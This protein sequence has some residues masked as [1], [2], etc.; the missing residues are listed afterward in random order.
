MEPARLVDL[1]GD[2]RS[3]AALE[4]RDHLPRAVTSSTR[5]TSASSSASCCSARR[6]PIRSISGGGRCP[7]G[8]RSRS[9]IIVVGGLAIL[10]RLRLLEIAVFFWVAFAAGIAVLAASGHEMTSRWHL[11]PVTGW[12]FWRV[13]VFSPEILVFLFFMITDPKTIPAGRRGRR[14]YA[15]GIGLLAMLLIAP[16]T[17]EFGTKVAVLGALA[18]VCAARPVVEVARREDRRAVRLRSGRRA[19]RARWRRGRGGVRGPRRPRRH[20]RQRPSTAAASAPRSRPASC[21][22]SPSSPRRA[23]RRRSTGRRRVR[24]ASDLVANLRVEGEA[25]AGRDRQRA[26]AAAAGARLAALWQQIDAGGAEVVVPDYDLERVA[27]DA[28][29]RA[30]ARRRRSSSPKLSGTGELVAYS[31]SPPAVESRGDPASFRQDAR[32]RPPGRP[33]RD[34][35]LARGERRRLGRRSP[36]PVTTA[37]GARRHP[38]RRRRPARR[39]RLPARRLPLR[40]LARPGGD[41]GRRGLLARL[42]RRRVARPLRR[43]LVLD[44]GR[45]RALEGARRPAAERSLPERRTGSSRREPRLRRRRL[46]C[47]GTAASP[48]TSTGDGRTDLYVTATGYD[49]LLWNEGDGTFVEGARAAGID[50]YG[51]HTAR[52]G[53]RRERR[54]AARPVRRGLRRPECAGRGR[55]RLPVDLR[56]RSRPPLPATSGRDAAGHARFREVGRQAG[57]EADAGGARP[58]GRVHRRRRRRAGRPLR[59]QRPRPEPALPERPGL[60]GGLGFRFVERGGAAGVADR[61]A[62]MGVAA[63]DCERRRSSRPVRHELPPPAPRRLREPCDR[64]RRSRMRGRASRRR[65]TRPSQAGASPGRTSTSTGISTSRSRTARFR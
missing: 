58:R 56:R 20:S 23:S 19:G 25:L 4:V 34:R 13:L 31:G 44:R 48:P 53:R 61:N 63:A 2:G 14:V 49:A 41:D 5:R 59:R 3:R 1:R 42:R 9:A 37:A 33:L 21:R 39:A 26:T 50:T 45:R 11:G 32:A 7:A 22:R 28:A 30:T 54:R 43:Q 15:V 17:T 52:H 29:S 62:G 64:R 55:R 10:T 65:S 40:D 35:G 24:I 8:W 46:R 51:W 27:A 47:V 18:L 60:A 6:G 38:P 36:A 12:E 57:I 16:Q